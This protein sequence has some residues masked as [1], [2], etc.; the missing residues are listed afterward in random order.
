[1]KDEIVF[2]KGRLDGEL[3]KVLKE[4]ATEDKRS[5]AYLL[6]EAVKLLV[7]KHKSAKA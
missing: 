1:M 2:V 6:N 4:I 5:I 3:H 7:E